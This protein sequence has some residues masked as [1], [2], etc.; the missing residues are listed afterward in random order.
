VVA[1]RELARRSHAVCVLKG[2]RT[3]VCDGSRNGGISINASGSPAL[4]TAGSGD[5]L[6]G[7]IGALLAQGLTPMAAA[8]LGTMAHG[9]AG[10]QSERA[11]G[12]RAVTAS[13]ICDAIPAAFQHLAM[14]RRE[15]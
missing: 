11:L 7:V 9:L 13:D 5:V 12:V 2:P 3:L 14:A 8:Q 15:R 10:E 1:V 4:A 6:S